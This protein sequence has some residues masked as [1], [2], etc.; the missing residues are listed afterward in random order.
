MAVEIDEDPFEVLEKGRAPSLKAMQ[1]HNSTV[2]RWTRPCY[3]VTDG[4]PHLRIE[5]RLFP[6]GPT[7]IDEVANAAFWFGLISGMAHLYKDITV[8]LNFDDVK[9]N[10]YA[11][12]RRGLKGQFSWMK[13]ETIP[14]QDLILEQ[15]LP[16]ASDGLLEAGVNKADIE[17]YLGVIR[18]RVASGQTGSEWM[19]RSFAEMKKYDSTDKCLFTITKS[20]Y[21]QQKR[22]KPVHEWP[23]AK[24]SKKSDLTKHYLKVEQLMITDLFTVNKEDSINLVIN[25]MNWRRIRHIPVEDNKSRLV[26]LV[27]YRSLVRFIQKQ[28]KSKD[29]DFTISP[30]SSI[31]QKNVPTVEPETP[32]LEAIALMRKNGASCL[33]VVSEGRL[34][35][36]VT[37]HDFMNLAAQFLE[38]GLN[39]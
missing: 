4:N 31:M 35:G 2:Y 3:G 25:V 17:R 32:T 9:G 30:V 7:V 1:L 22:G 12:A 34:V 10:F 29:K 5:N 39:A 26:G 24:V 37:E 19:T 14:A 11:A 33:P 23:L 13:E 18:A 20:I 8:E 15:L 27:N 21:R 38:S 36:I 16:L 28:E 6:S